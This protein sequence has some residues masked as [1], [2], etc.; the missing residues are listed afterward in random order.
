[1]TGPKTWRRLVK[2]RKTSTTFLKSKLSVDFFDVMCHTATGLLS[3]L[4]SRSCDG[5]LFPA[6]QVGQSISKF[7]LLGKGLSFCDI[8][9][10]GYSKSSNTSKS[11]FKHHGFYYKAV[12]LTV[13]VNAVAMTADG[14][15]GNCTDGNGLFS[16]FSTHTGKFTFSA[17]PKT[18]YNLLIS[19]EK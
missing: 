8:G 12:N 3:Q 19:V 7:D 1:M 13:I 11:L 4:V 5:L 17:Q 15:C 6:F 2:L 14:S 9:C 10:K 18:I 16:D